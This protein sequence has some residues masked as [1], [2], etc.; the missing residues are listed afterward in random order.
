VP[1]RLFLAQVEA[2]VLIEDLAEAH[3]CNQHFGLANERE[4]RGT[5]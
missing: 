3:V 4:V 2:A 1:A 5:A